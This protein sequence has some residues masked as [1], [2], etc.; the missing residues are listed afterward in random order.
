VDYSL[1]LSAARA[2]LRV[3]G[4]PRLTG[5][6]LVVDVQTEPG[7]AAGPMPWGLGAHLAELVPGTRTL[8]VSPDD[9]ATVLAEASSVDSVVVVTRE[10]HRHPAV[11]EFLAGLSTVDY[12]RVET[13]VPGPETGAGP[14]IDTFS[15][16]YVSLRAAA[17]YLARS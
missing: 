13:G 1:G 15:G 4:T 3:T 2:A 11:R 9:V 12:I 6:A 7:I 5:R 10:A 8:S 17:E 16:S 14:R